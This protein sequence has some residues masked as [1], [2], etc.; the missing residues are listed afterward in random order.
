MPP[1]TPVAKLKVQL[2]SA[3]L[4]K[5][6]A[7]LSDSEIDIMYAMMKDDDIQSVLSSAV[8]NQGSVQ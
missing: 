1:M 8:K 3:L 4:Q 7:D 5:H 2:Y 6:R